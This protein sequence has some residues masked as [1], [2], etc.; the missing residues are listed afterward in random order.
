LFS[1]IGKGV[2]IG[3]SRWVSIF[4]ILTQRLQQSYCRSGPQGDTPENI[5]FEGR[6]LP[7]QT[8][9]LNKKGGCRLGTKMGGW[10]AN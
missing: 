7:G 4:E 3:L 2:P 10:L 9:G 1:K 6:D 8:S 5:F